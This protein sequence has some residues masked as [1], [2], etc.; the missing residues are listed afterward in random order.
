MTVQNKKILVIDDNPDIGDL[1]ER[2]LKDSEYFVL[3]ASNGSDGI[4]MAVEQNVDVIL[5]DIM[6]P[7]LDG[8]TIISYLKKMPSTERIPVIFLTARASNSGRLIASKAGAADYFVKPFSPKELLAR[9]REI[10]S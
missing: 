9:I 4:A 10:T 5:L 7:N 3:K 8:F 2:A 6:M 1:V